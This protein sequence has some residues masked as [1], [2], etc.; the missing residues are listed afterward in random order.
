MDQQLINPPTHN[1][2][3]T[4]PTSKCSCNYCNE[5]HNHC[6]Q[7]PARNSKDFALFMLHNKSTVY[8]VNGGAIDYE[9]QVPLTID[10]LIDYMT[11]M[12]AKVVVGV[13]INMFVEG[14][15]M[16]LMEVIDKKLKDLKLIEKGD[17]RDKI[18]EVERSLK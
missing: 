9:S 4:L 3:H 5:S 8:L 6:Y 13:N 7:P 14:I 10:Y 15:K 1:H 2:N 17:A 11:E 12:L 16:E 18:T